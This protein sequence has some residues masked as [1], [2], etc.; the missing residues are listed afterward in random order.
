MLKEIQESDPNYDPIPNCKDWA[1]RVRVVLNNFVDVYDTMNEKLGY[2]KKH[3]LTIVHDKE[4]LE[5]AIQN[6][7]LVQWEDNKG[8]RKREDDPSDSMVAKAGE[9]DVAVYVRRKK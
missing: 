5:E 2:G 8:K 4:Q 9:P 7:D 3:K 1:Q 6:K